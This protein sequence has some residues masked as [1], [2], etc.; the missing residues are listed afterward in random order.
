M[1]RSNLCNSKMD[2]GSKRNSSR[3]RRKKMITKML[4][5]TMINSMNNNSNRNN[6]LIIVNSL[7]DLLLKMSF[8]LTIH[9]IF[10]RIY[11]QIK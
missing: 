8:L 11:I 5:L 7:I 10:N 9:T 6:I 4:N 3:S 1:D 2:K